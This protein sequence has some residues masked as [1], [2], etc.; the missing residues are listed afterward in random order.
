MKFLATLVGQDDESLIDGVSRQFSLGPEKL[1]TIYGAYHTNHDL[2][3]RLSRSSMTNARLISLDGD[4]K[5]H[6][7][8]LYVVDGLDSSSKTTEISF[9]IE[10]ASQG[11]LACDRPTSLAKNLA[12][13]LLM[14]SRLDIKYIK[15]MDLRT[16]T[17]N[18][19]GPPQRTVI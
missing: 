7:F 13:M 11:P 16:I 9:A 6:G 4:T 15:M 2:V 5:A 14:D 18:K 17:L 19:G 8:S 3:I 10:V 12:T 1:G